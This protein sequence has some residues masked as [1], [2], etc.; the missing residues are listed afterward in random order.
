MMTSKVG[1]V[2]DEKSI[3]LCLALQ[4]FCY[5]LL[6][7]PNCSLLFTA[8][9]KSH[10]ARNPYIS[11]QFQIG[12]INKN[13]GIWGPWK[14]LEII[15]WN[16]IWILL[17]WVLLIFFLWFWPTSLCVRTLS[18]PSQV[19]TLKI[20]LPWKADIGKQGLQYPISFIACFSTLSS[21]SMCEE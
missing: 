16:S 10:G 17:H 13:M 5:Y 19:P 7:T 15:I 1:W 6:F 21:N 3:W 14:Y 8:H 20:F 2:A 4:G 11:L 18:L 12:D 9:P